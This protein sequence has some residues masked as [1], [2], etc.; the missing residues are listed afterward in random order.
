MTKLFVILS[1]KCNF[2]CEHCINSSGPYS[3]RF[4]LTSLEETLISDFINTEI[5]VDTLSFTGGEPTLHLDA[6]SRIQSNIKRPIRYAITTNGSF[7]RNF[8][9][10]FEAVKLDEITI[11]FDKFHKSF[12]SPTRIE[13]LIK[14]I[15]LKG[16]LVSLNITYESL[17]DLS[18]LGLSL[19]PEVKIN[20]C[21]AIA[22]GRYVR[23]KNVNGQGSDELA[24]SPWN[25]KCPS[26]NHSNVEGCI[27]DN[28][29]YFPGKG[30]SF[31]A[32]PLTFDSICVSSSLY[33]E[34]S[35]G[36][37]MKP[38]IY[39]DLKGQTMREIGA[40]FGISSFPTEIKTP[41]EA[42]A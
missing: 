5:R 19:P 13:K 9:S 29:I 3:T 33:Q 26:L 8:N 34:L 12:I 1:T 24:G 37:L 2:T 7:D 17:M 28:L 31:C 27:T 22:G 16:K 30:L 42:C 32:G 20:L 4:T 40:N 21:R 18:T 15:L 14:K 36:Y 23:S 35:K 11:S 39:S 6:I 25:E 41:C 38:E 10:V